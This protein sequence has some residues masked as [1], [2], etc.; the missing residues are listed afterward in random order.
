MAVSEIVYK[1]YLWV[2]KDVYNDRIIYREPYKFDSK[3]Q[4]YIPVPEKEKTIDYYSLCTAF[5]NL[6][7]V[8]ENTPSSLGGG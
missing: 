4:T 2:Q 6:S 7:S 8:L 3:T 1:Y 5:P